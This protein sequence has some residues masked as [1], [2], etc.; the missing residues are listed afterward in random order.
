MRI[1]T[2]KNSA[3]NLATRKKHARRVLHLIG[4][5]GC[6]GIETWLLHILRATDRSELAMDFLVHTPDPAFYDEE[7]L[8]LGARIIFAGHHNAPVQL[9]RRMSRAFEALG[10]YDVVHS[11]VGLFSGFSLALARYH[12]VPTRIAHSHNMLAHPDHAEPVTRKLYNS[13]MTQQIHFHATHGLAAS[14]EAAQGL[15]GN[16]WQ[17]DPRIQVLFCGLDFS[18]FEAQVDNTA[19]RKQ[20]G[21]SPDN[22]VL[23]HI[24]SF[25]TQKNHEFLLDIMYH[26]TQKNPKTRLLLIGDGPLAN[27]I[28]EKTAVLGLQEHIH[29]AGLRND[30]AS[31]LKAA[32]AFVFPSL[33]EGLGLALVEA[34]AAGL[35]CFV[36]DT[37]P[38]AATILPQ[39][40]HRLPLK[41]GAELWAD[42]ISKRH[43]PKPVPQTDA[44][45]AVR[46]S[47]FDI[48][49]SLNHLKQVYGLRPS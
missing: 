12:K 24:G 27:S 23:A 39:T 48:L 41:A 22:L 13:L 34:Q 30:V 38:A 2:G 5:M 10:P 15:F 21:F 17:Q 42:T 36:S 4:S 9:A 18:A 1:A 33:F 11:H 35:P 49:R 25:S 14:P 16:N 20:F 47:P 31:I 40:V 3:R 26:L 44:L 6:G 46:E 29:F 8:D 19:I 45:A 32:D 37:V 28:R 7:I 43:T